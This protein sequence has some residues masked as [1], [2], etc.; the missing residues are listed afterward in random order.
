MKKHIYKISFNLKGTREQ[1]IKEAMS[2]Y[3]HPLFYDQAV[4]VESGRDKVAVVNNDKK[5]GVAKLKKLEK[6]LKG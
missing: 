4:M 2:F 3:K 1:V 6:L 5:V